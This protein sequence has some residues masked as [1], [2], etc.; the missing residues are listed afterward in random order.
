MKPFIWAAALE[1]GFTPAT[2]VSGAPIVIEDAQLEDEWRPEDY[3]KKFFGPTR[4]RKALALSLNL[5]SIRLLRAIGPTYAVG[6]IEEHFGFDG[7]KMP[8]NL[9]L[10]LG[11]ASATPM[12]MTSA[13]AVFAN[14]GFQIEPYFIT[15]IEDADH[16]VLFS[17]GPTLACDDCVPKAPPDKPAKSDK[18]SDKPDVVAVPRAAKR[19]L[20]PEVAFLMTSMMRDVIREGTGR[21]ALVLNRKDLAGKTGTTNEYRD[22]W[23]VGYNSDLVVTSWVGFDQPAPL[24]RAETGGRA[25]L[26]I[27]ID[28]M[29]E[30]LPS[31]PEKALATPENIVKATVNME[32]GKPTEPSDPDALEEY[33]VKG[34]ETG[35]EVPA[36]AGDP[37]SPTAPV[38][39]T[40]TE[41]VREKLF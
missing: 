6:Y 35:G 12:Q 17:A 40:Q 14:G 30:V 39:A 26:P 33:F 36:V 24:G 28:Y 13:Y 20:A 4:L 3:S 9:S 15:R 27:W 8:K 29:R 38:P 32:T 21:A 34:T 22:A 19:T 41:N 18:S 10:A 23:F 25:A 11:T 7:T 5:V 31:L 37:S 1:K 16:N 2:T